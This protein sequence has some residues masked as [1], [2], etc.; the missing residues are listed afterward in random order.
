MSLPKLFPQSCKVVKF[1]IYFTFNTKDFYIKKPELSACLETQFIKE[2]QPTYLIL[3]PLLSVWEVKSWCS[4]T[5][6][7]VILDSLFAYFILF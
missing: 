4:V 6:H 7:S 2:K 3:F 5:S 1:I